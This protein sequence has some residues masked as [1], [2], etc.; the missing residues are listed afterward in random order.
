MHPT[1]L[2]SVRVIP[3]DFKNLWSFKVHSVYFSPLLLLGTSYTLHHCHHLEHT[4][5]LHFSWVQIQLTAPVVKRLSVRFSGQL[6]DLTWFIVHGARSSV[7]P[8]PTLSFPTLLPHFLIWEVLRSPTFETDAPAPP[9]VWDTC[10]VIHVCRSC[11]KSCSS[12]EKNQNIHIISCH[13]TQGNTTT[14]L[15]QE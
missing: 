7:P 3:V 10:T 11:E 13:P 15:Y 14:S 5:T 4:M 12:F 6:L 1:T 8:L 9:G 2:V